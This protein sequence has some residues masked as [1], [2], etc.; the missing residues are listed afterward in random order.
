MLCEGECGGCVDVCGVC[1][2]GS[3][4]GVWRCVECV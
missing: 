2:K 3:V 4:E 1:V